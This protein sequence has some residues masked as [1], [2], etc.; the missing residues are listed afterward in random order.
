[1]A[2]R[3]TNTTP[4]KKR[5]TPSGYTLKDW[6]KAKQE[7]FLATLADTANVTA[8]AKAVRFKEAAAYDFRR[9]SPAFRAAWHEALGEGYTRLELM[10]LE[11]AMTALKPAVEGEAPD[12]ARTRVEEYSNKL[13][14]G[15][16]AAHRA[17]VRGDRTTAPGGPRNPGETGLA[18]LE[19]LSQ[20]RNHAKASGHV[21]P[22]AQ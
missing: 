22:P 11:R 16:L 8:S 20:M 7:K 5:R 13:A 12:P 17:T 9:R 18:M 3:P 15:L 14:M 6:S 10:M 1:M 19:A 21:A 2:S 4:K